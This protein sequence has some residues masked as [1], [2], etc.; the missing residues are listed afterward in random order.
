MDF[1][2][3][4]IFYFQLRFAAIMAQGDEDFFLAGQ[5]ETGII[6]GGGIIY[7]NNKGDIN[8]LEVQLKLILDRHFPIKPISRESLPNFENIMN[9]EM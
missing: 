9:L 1:Y 4:D 8:S 2:I 5:G 7:N 3:M 6:S